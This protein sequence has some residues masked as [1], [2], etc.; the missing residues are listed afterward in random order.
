[1][2]GCSLW[3]TGA[4][5]S[6]II[7]EIARMTTLKGNRVLFLVHRRELIEQ[8]KETFQFNGVDLSLVHF[9]MVQTVVRRLERMEKPQLIKIGR[10]SCRERVEMWGVCR[11]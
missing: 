1:M 10:A 11:S 2:C 8:I 9:G 4:G 3:L 5:K 7:A 6:V